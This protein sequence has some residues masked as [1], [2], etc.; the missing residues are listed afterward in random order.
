[1]EIFANLSAYPVEVCELEH[2]LEILAFE[3]IQDAGGPGRFRGGMSLRRDH[4]FVEAEGVLQVRSD[5]RAF[6]PFGLYGG[7]PGRPAQNFFQPATENR[8]LGSELTMTNKRRDLFPPQM[9]GGGG[10][11]GAPAR[12]P[13]RVLRDV[14]N[15]FVSLASAHD[16]YGVVIDTSAWRI[17]EEATRRR[18]AEL[19]AARG[20][21][22]LPT[23]VR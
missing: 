7:R 5:R 4:R 10:L 3:F 9:P 17:H 21:A 15:E 20:A 1:A 18:R 19:R 2:P 6:R 23:V 13:G 8:V 16:D 12:Q 11:G 22:P 14:R